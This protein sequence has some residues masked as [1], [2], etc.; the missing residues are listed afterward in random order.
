V[1]HRFSSIGRPYDGL[2]DMQTGRWTGKV[3][4]VPGAL[5]APLRWR[6]PSRVFV[7]SMSDLF[8]EDVP[9]GFI[10]QVFAVM[11]FASQHT[12]QC[13]TKRPQLMRAYMAGAAN[14]A[15]RE[16]AVAATMNQPAWLPAGRSFPRYPAAWPLPNVWL[17]VSVEDQ[18]TTDERIPLLLQTPAAVRFLSVEPLLGPVDLNVAA[19]GEGQRHQSLEIQARMV[20]PPGLN[21]RSGF[22]PLRALDWV[23][24]GGESGPGARPCD[25]AW[26]R[27]IIAQ[28][29]AADVP[30]FV[31]QLGARSID[32]EYRNGVYS[33]IDQRAIVAAKALGGPYPEHVGFNLILLR[34]RKGGEPSEWPE[35]LRMR[36][37]PA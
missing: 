18:E 3:R 12:F 9:E 25:L 24:V 29:K 11:A 5:E 17:G 2:T 8:H 23:I 7:D 20:A 35:D 36:E 13:L 6:K 27:S 32:S 22:M 14:G 21:W 34:D 30:V 4:L 1:A 15:S 33:D 10:D 19:W 26:I 37:W 16:T 28:C 31:K